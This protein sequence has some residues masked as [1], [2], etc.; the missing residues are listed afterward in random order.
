M[1]VI[2]KRITALLLLSSFFMP[3]SR[4]QLIESTDQTTSAVPGSEL[5][6]VHTPT[7]PK[8]YQLTP[9]SVFS[10][11]NPQ[12]WLM[13]FAFSWPVFVAILTM[14]VA[15]SVKRIVTIMEPLFCIASGYYIGQAL[16]IGEVLYGGYV[17]AITLLLYFLFSLYDSYRSLF[18]RV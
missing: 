15:T 17:A 12:S 6:A 14:V 13:L 2:L 7:A 11:S 3:L 8:Y 4:C 5:H 16:A 18:V 10:R 9:A 1:L